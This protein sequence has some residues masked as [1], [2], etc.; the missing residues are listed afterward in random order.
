MQN[1]P[2]PVIEQANEV[3]ECL[4]RLAARKQQLLPLST[5][6][7]QLNSSFRFRD[8]RELVSYLYELGVSTCYSSPILKAR[9]GSAHG[10]DITDHSALNPEIGT[11]E[12]LDELAAELHRH[13][14]GLLLDVVPNHMGVGYG[15]NPWWQD[16]LQNGRCSKF[17][18]FFDIDWNPLRPEL[19]NKVLLPILGN[20][21]GEELETGKLT[22]KYDGDFFIE[23]YD[24]MLPVDPQTVPLIFEPLGDLSALL[25]E[26]LGHE[27]MALLL[28]FAELPAHDTAE[29]DRVLARQREVPFLRQR[30]RELIERRPEVRELVTEAVQR[31]NGR[32][33]GARSFDAFH[34]LLEAQAYR[35]AHWRV[36]TEEINYRRFFDINDLVGLRMEDPQV[37][38]ATSA[39]IRRLLAAGIATSLRVDHPDGLFN[40]PQFFARL[41][42]LYAASQCYGPEPHL[43]QAENGV[44][45]EIQNIFSQS[46]GNRAP[47]YVAVEKILQPGEEL[48]KDWPV[49]GTV[50]YDFAHLVNGIFIDAANRR[51]FTN[52]YQRFLGQWMD[53]ESVI[54]QSK[55]LIMNV[56]LSSELTVLSHMLDEISSLDRNARDFTRSVLRDAIRET[57]A[58]FPVYRTYIDER[59]NLSERDRGHINE[60]IARAKRRNSGMPGSVFEFLR[61]ILLLRGG[62]GGTPI[63]GY[64]RQLYFTLKF[65]QLTAPVMAKGLEDTACY[66]YNR[67]VSVNDVGGSP[68]EFGVEMDEFHRG[69]LQRLQNWPC[70]MLATSTHDS[71]RSEDVRM[72]LDVLSEIPRPWAAQ[73]LRWRRANR[74]KKHSLSDGRLVPDANEEYLL[75]Q[76][77]VGAWPMPGAPAREPG[78]GNQR[79]ALSWSLDRERRKEFTARIQAYMTKAVSEAKVNTSWISPNQEYLDG[80]HAFIAR[81]LSPGSESRPNRFLRQ[82]EAFVAK[83]A[84]FGAINSLSQTLIKLTSPGVPDIYQGQELF[85]FSLVDPDNRR[86]VN[87]ELRRRYLRALVTRAHDSS[88]LRQLCEEM[89]RDWSDGRL[90]LWVTHHALQARQQHRE[91]FQLGGYLPLKISGQKARHAVAFARTSGREMAITVTPRFAYSMM[92]GEERMPLGEA[93]G[94]A[95]LALPAVAAEAAQTAPAKTPARFT[96]LFTGEVIEAGAQGALLCREV[97]ASFPVA[98][99]LR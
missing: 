9:S 6:R 90:K 93:W 21:Y 91:L 39:L 12:E 7:L 83:V 24:K 40:P 94:N 2:V 70:S 95:E 45:L 25:G 5:Y 18:N 85:D 23:Y 77:L 55:K 57:I 27:F 36:S 71:K 15:S 22:L 14:M 17:A 13:G 87:F 37:F 32:P 43:P 47:L 38:A 3:A 97:F 78:N 11:Q 89:L 59:G 50:G 28:G 63:Y 4:E 69:N 51:A 73:A 74:G 99:L 35:L 54:Y 33:G 31:I 66:V 49:D 82:L 76:T 86:A 75:Y 10:Y 26:E 79:S 41:Q 1:Q 72:R 98:L 8:A 96:N 68:R 29:L 92:D 42:M 46:S 56:A 30:L 61:D 19:R 62:D 53:V 65:Q 88:Q 80:L 67:L 58:C 81:I 52:F 20:Q 34:K 48:P 60:A 64:R 16:V 84:L 44:E